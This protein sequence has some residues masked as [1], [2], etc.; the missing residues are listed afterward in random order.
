MK[1]KNLPLYTSICAGLILM[2]TAILVYQGKA[3]ALQP[4][5]LMSA[6]LLML[7]HAV[8]LNRAPAYVKCETPDQH[9]QKPLSWSTITTKKGF[10]KVIGITFGTIVVFFGL[11][12][13]IGRLLFHV[14]H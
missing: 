4:T 8:L 12:F 5:L 6:G 3:E 1:R 11:G 7:V 9:G 2:L 10:L 13:L 14:I